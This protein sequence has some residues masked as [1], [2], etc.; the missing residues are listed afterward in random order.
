MNRLYR[1]LG[2]YITFR[3]RWAELLAIVLIAIVVALVFPGTPLWVFILIG[4]AIG[5][6]GDA[7]RF[8][9][10]RLRKKPGGNTA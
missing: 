2:S 4:I 6:A 8:L 10:R 9:G 7:G 1:W 5:F 3:L